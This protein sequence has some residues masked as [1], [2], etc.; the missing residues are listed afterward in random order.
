MILPREVERHIPHLLSHCFHTAPIILVFLELLLVYHRYPDNMKGILMVFV[1]CTAYIVWIVWVFTK[2]SIWPY[3]FF[4]LI[5]LPALPVF[6]LTN[7][8]IAVLF[9]FAGKWCCYLRWK[10]E[11][12]FDLLQ[13]GNHSLTVLIE[14]WSERREHIAHCQCMFP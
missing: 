3:G 9:Y 4:K 5:P 11:S 13:A 14:G 12:Y 6:F 8:V 2:A 7:F 10:G 1:M